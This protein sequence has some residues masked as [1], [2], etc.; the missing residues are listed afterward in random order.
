MSPSV[1]TGR[2]VGRPTRFTSEARDSFLAALS[3]NAT[4]KL[5][6][7]AAG[8]GDRTYIDYL[9]AGLLAREASA[10]RDLTDREQ[11]FA[12]FA[13]AVESVESERA[14]RNLGVIIR[15]AEQQ[16]DWKA[17]AWLLERRYAEDFAKRTSVELT[18]RN[19]APVEV[20]VS[21]S[22]LLD[23]LSKLRPASGVTI[24]P[25]NS[26]K[27]QLAPPPSNGHAMAST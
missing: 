27:L 12:E 24:P 3:L 4:R 2:P 25:Q 7:Q 9:N 1:R 16:N 8:W 14:Q 18:G 6:S 17:A 5:A 21:V 15:A 23:A 11:S 22:D 10:T 13:D 19:G 26:P 20:D